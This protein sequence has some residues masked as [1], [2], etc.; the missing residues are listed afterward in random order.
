M[1]QAG[2]IAAAGIV[3]L[4][5]GPTRL[6][7]DHRHVK[8]L[9]SKVNELG[10]GLIEVNLVTVETNMAMLKVT[11]NSQLT[12]ELLVGRLAQ[13]TQEEVQVLG[14]DIRVLA[15]PMTSTS[16]RVVVHCDITP[17]DIDRAIRKFK[18]VFE[19][20]RKGHKQSFN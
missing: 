8:H 1:R 10:T 9:A 20:F 11:P 2:V 7:A 5:K 12:P 15:Y 17:Q 13:S 18:F 4:S 16:V 3:A 6:E 19:E 14:E